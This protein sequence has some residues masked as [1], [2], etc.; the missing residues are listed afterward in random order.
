[1]SVVAKR[2]AQ[3]LMNLAVSDSAV[4]DSAPK[5]SATIDNTVEAVTAALDDFADTLEENPILAAFL[6]EPKVP[7]SGKEGAVAEV[8][9]KIEAPALVATFLRFLTHKRR[10]SLAGDIR[11]VFHELADA[12]LGRATAEVT[13]AA[14]LTAQQAEDLKARLETISGKQINLKITTDPSILGGIVAR[15]GSTVWDGSIRN[16]LNRVHQQLTQS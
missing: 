6:A 9:E 2:Y 12:R 7:Q 4:K 14:E 16:Q 15:I 5:N 11:D 13:V 1:M 3:A 8:L 10:I